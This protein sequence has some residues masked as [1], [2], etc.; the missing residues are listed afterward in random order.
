[1][2]TTTD[3]RRR[4]YNSAKRQPPLSS[5]APSP[6]LYCSM[7]GGGL[8]PTY[9]I[10][11]V[12]D[13]HNGPPPP[14][15]QLGVAPAAPVVAGIEPPLYCGMPGGGLTPTYTFI[16]VYDDHNGL[17]VNPIAAKIGRGANRLCR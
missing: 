3:R 12:Y 7:P 16:Y 10:I 14:P 11:Y 2:P 9:T 5:L 13:D 15:L 4:C 8:T 6:H 17:K 1:M